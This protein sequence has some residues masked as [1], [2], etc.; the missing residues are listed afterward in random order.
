MFSL[1]Y[2][3]H[4][5]SQP[6]QSAQTLQNERDPS[7]ER[8][9]DHLSHPASRLDSAVTSEYGNQQDLTS[10]TASTSQVDEESSNLSEEYSDQSEPL[11]ASR[12]NKYHGP[13]S[14]WRSWTA[15]E[16]GL[17]ESLD[18]LTAKDLAVHLYNVHALKKRARKV[19]ERGK[20]QLTDNGDDSINEQEWMPPKS[21]TAWPLP[22]DLVPREIDGPHWASQDF[23][24]PSRS[25]QEY[26]AQRLELQD[27]L[28]AQVTK[29]AKKRNSWLSQKDG[30]RRP[31]KTEP[32]AQLMEQSDD[33]S[34]SSKT[35]SLDE[36]EPVIMLDDEIA[37][38]LLQPMVYHILTKLDGLLE[39]LHHARNTY[40]TIDGSDERESVSGRSITRNTP[41]PALRR[42]KLESSFQ[43]LTSG[44]ETSVAS[45]NKLTAK[46]SRIRQKPHSR[47]G[48][49][50]NQR[51][52]WRRAN[53]GLRDWSDVLGVASMTGWESVIVQ[54]AAFRC[55][56]LFDEGIK[57]RTLEENGNGPTENSVLPNTSYSNLRSTGDK[58]LREDR[59]ASSGPTRVTD[60]HGIRGEGSMWK[61]RCP[62]TTCNRSSWGFSSSYALKRHMKQVHQ[63]EVAFESLGVEESEEGMVG[64]VH[65]DG[66]LQPIPRTES[67]IAKKR[68]QR[69][70]SRSD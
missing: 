36:I 18:Q 38:N 4:P 28:V 49:R 48:K 34:I 9:E 12:S 59:C 67:W 2:E 19:D 26:Q 31:F 10:P 65:V 62:V 7:T 50:Q 5:S 64:G 47:I 6:F 16:R 8:E 23:C 22:P 1:D 69:P 17:A 24:Q 35:E 56:T 57:F 58:M 15:S 42:N 43:P 63:N 21:W 61:F 33:S 55:S 40:M 29:K 30:E 3:S 41:R 11:Q 32:E 51:L 13:K 60:S 53:F 45:N 68:P 66:F 70:K 14:T 54:K 44:P 39:G 37:K 20:A 52:R 27:L 25:N 46:N